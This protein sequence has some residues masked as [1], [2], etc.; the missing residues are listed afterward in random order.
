MTSDTNVR[1]TALNRI[2][3]FT[4]HANRTKQKETA[5]PHFIP[6]IIDVNNTFFNSERL[7]SFHTRSGVSTLPLCSKSMVSFHAEKSLM[8]SFYTLRHKVSNVSSG[9][10]FIRREINDLVM[11]SIGIP[12]HPSLSLYWCTVSSRPTHQTH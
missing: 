9:L 5:P 1:K 12:C 3:I 2:F 8:T 6:W 11:A 10:H 7:M 4:H